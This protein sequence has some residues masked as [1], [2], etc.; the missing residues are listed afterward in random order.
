M[1]QATRSAQSRAGNVA[2]A[3]IAPTIQV[4][5]DYQA[6]RLPAG[7]SGTPWRRAIGEPG[8]ALLTRQHPPTIGAQGGGSRVAKS[9]TDYYGVAEVRGR[10]VP[11]AFDVKSVA[12]QVSFK[13]KPT[14]SHQVAFMHHVERFGG[15][16]FFLLV[17]V[18]WS[19]AWILAG[20]N[21][22]ALEAGERVTF[23]A[24]VAGEPAS[25][26]VPWLAK[27]PFGGLGFWGY[28]FLAKLTFPPEPGT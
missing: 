7:I 27:G 16:G 19:T 3:A 12:S 9:P 13:L 1:T 20:A 2:E 25:H 18:P 15:I 5:R 10:Q 21:L 24:R 26:R 11:L 4:Y 23:C 22:A 17:D 28:D 8:A 14:E 6:L